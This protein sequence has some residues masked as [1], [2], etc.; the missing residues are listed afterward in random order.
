MSGIRYPG[1]SSAVRWKFKIGKPGRFSVS[2]PVAAVE[3]SSRVI[4]EISGQSLNVAVPKTGNYGT[5]Q[6]LDCGIITLDKAQAYELT[7]K[8]VPAGWS[9]INLRAVTLKPVQ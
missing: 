4:V 1:T 5:Y 6:P 2:A 3:A 8:P 7:V 9:P